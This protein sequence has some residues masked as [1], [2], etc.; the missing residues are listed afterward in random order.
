LVYRGALTRTAIMA[1]AEKDRRVSFNQQQQATAAKSNSDWRIPPQYE[2]RKAIGKGSYGHVCEAY[3]NVNGRLVAIK[4]MNR[5]FEDLV[6]C[7]RILRELAILSALS[8]ANPDGTIGHNHIVKAY[9][10]WIPEPLDRFDE[11][12]VVLE[13][14]DTDL[15]KLFRTPAFLSELHVKTLL[16]NLLVGVNYLHHRGIYHRDLKPANCLVMQDCSLKICD[17]G[18]SRAVAMEQTPMLEGMVAS[19]R[20]PLKKVQPSDHVSRTLTQHVVTRWYR[21]PELILL[22]E[23]YDEKIDVW[24]VGCIFGELLGMMESNIPNSRDRGPLFP[25]SSC[26]PLSP[27]RDHERDYKFHTKGN[28]DQLA[29]IVGMLGNPDA[30]FIESLE[31]KEAQVYMKCFSQ[32]TPQNLNER[33]PGTSP[34]G[35]DILKKMLVIDPRYRCAVPELLSHPYFTELNTEVPAH[36]GGQIFLNFELETE[37]DEKHLRMYFIKELQRFRPE[38]QMPRS[39][40]HIIPK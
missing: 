40:A 20:D 13:V 31:K 3:D 8:A 32:R 18:L 4:K 12:Y 26:F 27:A 25:G 33:F 5:V 38:I 24:G 14:C 36:N 7:K 2:I 37:L 17:F 22:Q 10:L 39:L 29:A 19:P 1:Q 6:D 23:K 34:D 11:L 35:I 15:K 9:D 28:R 21:A 30:S 16:W